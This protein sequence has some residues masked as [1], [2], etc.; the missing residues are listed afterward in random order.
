MTT[1]GRTTPTPAKPRTAPKTKKPTAH[2]SIA[3][4]EAEVDQEIADEFIEAFTVDARDGTVVTFADPRNLDVFV[5]A[6]LDHRDPFLA[7]RTL[8][9]DDDQ[10]S[11]LVDGGFKPGV[12]N[13]LISAWQEH[14]KGA[15]VDL[16]N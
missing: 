1:T 8:V 16:G 7:F 5:M 3:Q 14:Y 2:F 10:Y 6:T 9:E 4:A 11:S 15:V 12:A 13:K